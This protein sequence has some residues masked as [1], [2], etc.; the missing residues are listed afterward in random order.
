MSAA[1]SRDVLENCSQDGGG[2]GDVQA[3]SAGAVFDAYCAMGVQAGLVAVTSTNPAATTNQ[4]ASSTTITPVSTGYVTATP[5][6]T[7][8]NTNSSSSHA[9]L[10]TTNAIVI[11]VVVSLGGIVILLAAWFMWRRQRRLVRDARA[12]RQMTTTVHSN[13]S[14][15]AKSPMPAPVAIVEVAAREIPAAEVSG[16]PVGP[17]EIGTYDGRF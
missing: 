2:V 6:T 4:I 5:T 8:S 10:S 14:H 9:S 12:W 1:I 3:R 11:G 7:T 16:Q 13:S 17:V 15:L